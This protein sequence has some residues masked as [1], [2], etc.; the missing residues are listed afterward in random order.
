MAKFERELDIGA[1]LAVFTKEL[2]DKLAI[3]IDTELVKQTPVD[4]GAAKRNW[5]ASSG[6]S[7]DTVLPA[8]GGVSSAQV[9]SITKSTP[10]YSA[11]YLQNNLPYI[12]RLNEGWS[13]QA[14]TRYIDAIIEQ[15]VAR[16][17]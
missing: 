2:R 14:P 8:G 1:D 16:V 13:Q 9:R 10:A 7:I 3:S 17:K 12:N 6:S 15:E 4:T 5:L 11:L